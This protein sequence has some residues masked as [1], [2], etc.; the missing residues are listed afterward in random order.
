MNTKHGI[1]WL[2][3]LALALAISLFPILVFGQAVPNIP[4]EPPK[5]ITSPKAPKEAPKVP[6]TPQVVQ[7]PNVPKEA[8]KVPNVPKPVNIPN[9]PKTVNVPNVPKNIPKVV[10]APKVPKIPNVPKNPPV[11]KAPP[12]V[13]IPD[14]PKVPKTPVVVKVP[15]APKVPK[16]AP[17]VPIVAKIPNAPKTPKDAPKAPKIPVVVEA[18]KVPKS[19][20]SSAIVS[21]A[22]APKAPRTPIVVK[23]VVETPQV[24]GTG[25]NSAKNNRT[26]A[27]DATVQEAL[28][29][30][31]GNKRKT[32]PGGPT[33]DVPGVD[34]GSAKEIGLPGAGKTTGS[35]MQ[36][37][38]VVLQGKG[39]SEGKETKLRKGTPT[40]GGV[41]TPSKDAPEPAALAK[42]LNEHPAIAEQIVASRSGGSGNI[43]FGN[44]DN[45]TSR[46]TAGNRQDDR[47]K[48]LGNGKPRP[49]ENLRSPQN[50]DEEKKPNYEPGGNNGR[51]KVALSQKASGSETTT[52]SSESSPPKT[53]QEALVQEA[54]EIIRG[55]Q[56]NSNPGGPTPD[57]PG[58]DRSSGKEIGLPGAGKTTE[59]AMKDAVAVLQG[60]GTS[61]GKQSTI[62]TDNNKPEFD[63]GFDN[64][65]KDID[66]SVK[67]NLGRNSLNA[68]TGR[69]IAGPLGDAARSSGEN[70]PGGIVGQ[71]KGAISD[72]G[73]FSSA[74]LVKTNGAGEIEGASSAAAMKKA[75]ELTGKS[76]AEVNQAV[77]N[78]VGIGKG[79]NGWEILEDPDGD[80]PPKPAKEPAT[81]STPPAAEPAGKIKT[82]KD[83]TVTQYTDPDG[84]KHIYVNTKKVGTIAPNGDITP[85]TQQPSDPDDVD[86]HDAESFAKFLNEHPAIAQQI[87]ASRS[88]GRGNIDFGNVDNT[89]SRGPSNG[90]APPASGSA[91]RNGVGQPG[92]NGGEGNGA[93]GRGG[94]DFNGNAGAKDPGPDQT[95]TA[96]GRQDD[97]GKA[98]GNGKP[99]PDE[100]LK[101]PKS[102]EKKPY[103]EP[104]KVS[105]KPKVLP[106]PKKSD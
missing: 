13:K 48:A 83:G 16:A 73:A 5:L 18:P 102:E 25:S 106:L 47:G 66:S 6:K 88:G 81:A 39:T 95:V 52:E 36:D 31:M 90:S 7:L 53:S 61:E 92:R 80:P 64:K 69:S 9:P 98:S 24:P 43:N 76:A 60:K 34:R 3:R 33:P 97:P 78:A 57:L 1:T 37:A 82:S 74:G 86:S 87:I 22:K 44:V 104:G 41:K 54:L 79:R 70:G 30:V 96:G 40:G 38:V 103:Y 59:S 23:K 17:K 35:A 28:N 71:G 42:F 68:L 91:I 10:E 93:N 58:V 19:S 56:R 20:N 77:K 27:K 11:V 15:D 89:T 12:V 99:K 85:T 84:T 72:G 14:A 49:S 55:N 75:Q 8:P 4:K 2:H 101:A 51:P 63:Q 26:T 100:N 62:P 67:D 21:S 32:N 45:T 105:G 65:P 94:L 29:I 50:K 46:G